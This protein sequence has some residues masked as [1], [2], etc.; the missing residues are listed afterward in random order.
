M[1]RYI[2]RLD[3]ATPKMNHQLWNE[4]ERMLDKYDIKPIVGVIPDSRDG[5]F[6]WEEDPDFWNV[7]VQR[8]QNKGWTIAQHGFHH[9]YHKV[10]ENAGG[11]NS[12]YID[13]NY[14]EQ[15]E[16]IDRGHEILLSHNCKPTCFFAPGHSFD[17]IT[18]DVCR[19]SGY[20]DFI[21][22]GCAIYPYK[23]R[24]ML[25]FPSI[26]DTPHKILPFG[27]YTFIMHPSF[28]TPEDINYF[29]KFI[30]KHRNN[31]KPVSEIMDEI[32]RDRTR[33]SLEKT[34]H[35]CIS[36]ARKARKII[37]KQ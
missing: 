21:S 3:D 2:A 33:N 14:E 13:L 10:S 15:K 4:V 35:P 28:T 17:E 20:F 18:V 6:K 5:L 37:K 7:T 11:G 23:E 32:S 31:F 19:D 27:V 26:F 30:Q 34:I 36:F 24:D 16:L 29:E 9:V 1:L 8:W 25:F 22:D 12:E